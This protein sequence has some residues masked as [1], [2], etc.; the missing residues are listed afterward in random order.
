MTVENIV[1]A[2]PLEERD[3]GNGSAFLCDFYFVQ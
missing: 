3:P 1:I 2:I